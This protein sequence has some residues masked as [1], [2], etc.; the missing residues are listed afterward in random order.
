MDS[1]NKRITDQ[2]ARDWLR[3]NAP[4]FLIGFLAVTG[5]TVFALNTDA[6]ETEELAT[7]VLSFN[8]PDKYSP[9]DTTL[10]A[11]LADGKTIQVNL[12]PGWIPPMAGKQ[13]RVKRITRLFFGERFVL[14]RQP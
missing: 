8:T 10:I 4:A 12:P 11:R 6:T 7:A 3:G 5:F 13:I 14:L 9:T 1:L 2:L